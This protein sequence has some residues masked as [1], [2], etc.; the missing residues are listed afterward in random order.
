MVRM[1]DYSGKASKKVAEHEEI[2]YLTLEDL[3]RVLD[4]LAKIRSKSSTCSRL[5]TST[6]LS[7]LF[8]I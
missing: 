8:I 2:E 1:K 6:L 4:E 7:F 5:Q 3:G